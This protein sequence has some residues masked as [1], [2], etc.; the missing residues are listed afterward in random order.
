MYNAIHN[1]EI[2]VDER[3]ILRREIDGGRAGMVAL[4]GFDQLTEHD[5]F[6]KSRNPETDGNAARRI[7]R[8]ADVLASLNHPQIPTFVDADPDADRPYIV[9]E[10]KDFHPNVAK[11]FELNPNPIFAAELCVAALAPLGYAH[12]AGFTHR[13]I[14]PAN[15]L[16]TW[17]GDVVLSDWEIA[18]CRDR[19]L[20]DATYK[21]ARYGGWRTTSFG[22]AWGSEG[23]MSPEQ[24]EGRY[25]IQ[26]G[27]SDIY[28]T[29]AVLHLFLHGKLPS[30]AGKKS[31]DQAVREVVADD[32]HSLSPDRSVPTELQEVTTRALEEKPE[33]RYQSAAEMSE[34][35][36]R[37]LHAMLGNL[38]VAA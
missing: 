13:D 25:K 1:P 18:L 12:E 22:L 19:T 38:R 20:A 35:L 9:T 30:P 36:E 15:L 26:D 27:R 10:L 21:D 32:D 23:Y 28:A 31:N 7:S 8:E 5:V 2:V 17:E 37:Y 6:I 16:M 29:G 3:Y 34:E 11:G 24:T 33:D 14:K 4:A